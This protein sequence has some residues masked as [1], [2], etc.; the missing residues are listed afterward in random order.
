MKR[1]KE[2]KKGF[3]PQKIYK[4]YN[5]VIS[6]LV[7]TK[8]KYLIGYLGKVIRPLVL[9]VPKISGYVERFKDEDEDNVDVFPYR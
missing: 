2:Q 8:S 9:I 3:M 1:Y 4:N 6:K 7:K 5:I